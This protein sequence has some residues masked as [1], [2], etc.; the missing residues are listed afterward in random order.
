MME[1]S[2]K[3]P[4]KPTALVAMS[5]SKRC[6]C[7]GKKGHLARNSRKCNTKDKEEDNAKAA[8]TMAM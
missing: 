4:E 3:P 6:H 7:C 5:T 2:L 1:A 8:V